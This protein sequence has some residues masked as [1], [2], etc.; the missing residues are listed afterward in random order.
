MQDM[1]CPEWQGIMDRRVLVIVSK[2][3]HNVN[4]R[5]VSQSIFEDRVKQVVN[6]QLS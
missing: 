3:G 5:L 6:I 2:E 1:K 4:D